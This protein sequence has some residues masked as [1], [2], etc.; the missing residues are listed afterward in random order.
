VLIGSA[1]GRCGLGRLG[2]KARMKQKKGKFK[3]G[4]P[5]DVTLEH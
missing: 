3:M 2:E 4:L 5:E 1:G